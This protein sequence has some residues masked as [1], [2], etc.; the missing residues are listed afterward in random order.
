MSKLV[1]EDL[2]EFMGVKRRYKGTNFKPSKKFLAKT[3]EVSDD[4]LGHIAMIWDE[5]YGMDEEEIENQL[6]ANMDY[7]KKHLSKG[8][9]PTD[10]AKVIYYQK[11]A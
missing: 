11:I 7:I 9:I 8:A 5:Q 2:N 10:L 4:E 6:E 1:K 3:Y